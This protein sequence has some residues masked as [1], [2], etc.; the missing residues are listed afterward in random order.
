VPLDPEVR[1]WGDRGTPVVQAAPS[2]SSA[3]AFASIADA[4]AERVA[5]EHFERGGGEAA[6]EG[7]GP[8]RLRILR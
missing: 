2:S 7:E 6:P 4:L 8:K 1:E 5:R 3:Q